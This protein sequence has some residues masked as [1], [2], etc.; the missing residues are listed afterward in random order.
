MSFTQDE[1]ES[2]H[3][4]LEQKL[5]SHRREL[6]LSLDQRM[7]VLRQ[8]FKQYLTA[9]EQDLLYNLP[10]RL[11]EQQ[12]EL[13][14][15]LIQRL[16]VPQTRVIDETAQEGTEGVELQAEIDWDDL[17]SVIDRVVGERLSTLEVTIQ[18]LVR[19]TEQTLLAELHTFQ[20][21][22]AQA[23]QRYTTTMT[24]D[25]TNLQDA[26]TSIEQLEHAMEALQVTLMANH[27][28]LSNRLSH[29]QRLPLE[30]AHP[31]EEKSEGV[32]Q[33]IQD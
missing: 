21:D 23:K 33:E 3:T 9:V 28:L 4:I 30:R 15:T 1:L 20:G 29:H 12:N 5:A 6:E 24:T 13:K 31:V 22:L 18:S 7:N 10:L 25:I 17:L 19:G 11:A 27:T 14:D 2:F 16:E 8:E 26:F 32:E